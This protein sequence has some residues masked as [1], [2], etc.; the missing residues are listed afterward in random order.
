MMR[1][2]LMRQIAAANKDINQF[3]YQLCILSHDEICIA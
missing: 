1:S 3:I 2:G